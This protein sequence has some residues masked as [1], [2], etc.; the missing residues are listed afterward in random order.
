[1]TVSSKLSPI[2]SALY[3][4]PVEGPEFE[5][6]Q[7]R[8]RKAQKD[9]YGYPVGARV[10]PM[11][12]IGAKGPEDVVRVYEGGGEE[13]PPVA[14]P[15]QTSIYRTPE[16]EVTPPQVRSSVPRVR[17]GGEVE[18]LSY[19]RPEAESGLGG[20][21]W[22][23]IM[24]G[25]TPALVGLLTGETEAGYG[26]AS[27]GLLDEA[28]R[29]EKR[30]LA[31]RKIAATQKEKGLGQLYKA[32][33]PVTGEEKWMTRPEA[34]GKEIAKTRRPYEQT[35]ALIE[36]RGDVQVRVGRIFGKGI[37]PRKD[38]DGFDVLVNKATGE[39]RRVETDFSKISDQMSK[40]LERAVDGFRKDAKVNIDG[41]RLA[42]SLSNKIGIG[43]PIGDALVKYATAKI[44]DGGGRLSDKD[45]QIVSEGGSYEEKV[46]QM[47]HMA[48]TGRMTEVQRK[49]FKK[50]VKVMLR[51]AQENINLDIDRTVK[52][53]AQNIPMQMT[54]DALS[55][56]GQ[57]IAKEEAK[58]GEKT[59]GDRK[60]IQLESGKWKEV[61]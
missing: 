31:D 13:K 2:G 21:D 24:I 16:Q 35:Q 4:A 56:Y 29:R 5:D 7:L 36:Q 54:K 39:S 8:K 15:M 6:E 46:N 9:K 60:F 14:T 43:N 55:V 51:E 26:L 19:A 3:M 30:A 33:D 11:I 49:W 48:K 42:K 40:R 47:I 45:V 50:I 18:P 25:A 53:R 58:K 41:L 23:A 32:T 52:S 22:G 57:K 59:I 27:K 44:A 17:S 10:E 38:S 20:M 12:G 34:H 37:V 61:K 1:M 28:G